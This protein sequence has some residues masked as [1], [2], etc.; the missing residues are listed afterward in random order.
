MWVEVKGEQEWRAPRLH[1]WPNNEKFDRTFSVVTRVN[2]SFKTYG[3]VTDSV[4]QSTLDTAYPTKKYHKA[5]EK[6]TVADYK[7]SV[8]GRVHI[9]SF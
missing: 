8:Q 5:T 4:N 9:A 7:K 3:G 2:T 6:K 1:F